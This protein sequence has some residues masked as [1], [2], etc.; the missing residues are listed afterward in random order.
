[1]GALAEGS[2]WF[3][4]GFCVLFF[5]YGCFAF[6]CLVLVWFWLVEGFWVCRGSCVGGLACSGAVGVVVVGLVSLVLV[7]VLC[8]WLCV[9]GFVVWSAVL[10]GVG[11]WVVRALRFFVRFGVASV[12]L[13]LVGLSY[14]F[15]SCRGVV[16]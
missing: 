11:V 7:C 16:C 10:W 2:G 5:G 13:G 8:L 12:W 9:C 15:G 1:M 3:G 4:G 14:G 6:C